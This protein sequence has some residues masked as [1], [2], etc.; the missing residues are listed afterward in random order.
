MPGV[1]CWC[2]DGIEAKA[3]AIIHWLDIHDLDLCKFE[4]NHGDMSEG[5]SLCCD[6]IANVTVSCA[7]DSE[8]ADLPGGVSDPVKGA[9]CIFADLS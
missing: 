7:F 9:S 1:T 8:P 5:D 3:E 2:V 6:P 4:A